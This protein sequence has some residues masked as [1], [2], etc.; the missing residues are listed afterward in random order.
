LRLTHEETNMN[1]KVVLSAMMAVTLTLSS[2]AFAEEGREHHEGHDRDEQRQ[3]REYEGDRGYQ[4]QRDHRDNY[5]H[6]REEWREAGA[7]PYHDFYRGDRLPR[8]YR[9]RSYVVDDWRDQRLSAP[10]RGY[11]WVQTGS[12]YVLVAIATGI[13]AQVLLGR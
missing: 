2:I 10:P 1:N 13:I 6:G 3:H 8:E 12:D 4:Y 9:Q 7:G 5:S 11:Y